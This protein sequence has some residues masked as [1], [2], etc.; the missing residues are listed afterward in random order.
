MTYRKIREHILFSS[1]IFIILSTL[2][3]ANPI[4]VSFAQHKQSSTDGTVTLNITNTSTD[5][6]KVL[7]WNTPLE[8]ILSANLFHIQK[9]K[10]SIPYTGRVV[11]R[12]SPTED[13]YTLFQAGE[14]R[15]VSISLPKYY[16]LS[17]KGTYDVTYNA[18]F[19][20]QASV[21]NVV[22]KSIP[23]QTTI[24]FTPSQQQSTLVQKTPANFNACS[25]SQITI[26]NS[27]HDEAIVIAKNAYDTLTAATPNTQGER[28]N[29]WF[30]APNNP[31]QT[32]ITTNFNKIHT[33]LDTKDIVFDCSCSESHIAHVYANQPYKIY[34]C[35]SFWSLETTGTDTHAG[36]VVHEVSH[37]NIVATTR[38]HAYGHSRAKALAISNPEKAAANAD[39]Y[40]YFAENSP[41]LTMDVPVID[42]QHINDIIGDLPLSGNIAKAEDYQ[43]F[44][45]T[46]PQ[47]GIYTFY[48][49]GD[50]DTQGSLYNA[51]NLQI[52]YNDDIIATQNLNFSVSHLLLQGQD[53]HLRINAYS[54]KTGNYVFNSTFHKVVASDFNADGVA[55]IMWR[56]GST[57]YIWYMNADGT[58]SH[59]KKL[60]TKSSKYK[61]AGIA[62][63]NADGV[64]DIM[65]RSGST[66]YI[67]YMNAD[68]SRNYKLINPKSSAYKVAGVADF[69]NDGI[70]DILW[71]KGST[72][73]IWY[74]NA[75]GTRDYKLINPKHAS[76]EV[77]GIADF[78]G[79]AVADILWRKKYG[80][81]GYIW[82][83]GTDGS[84]DSIELG[85]NSASYD[86][87]SVKDFNHDGIADIM[88]RS[89]SKSSIWYMKAN[90]GHKN[91]Y[92]KLS[93][94]SASYRVQQ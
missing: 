71:R 12:I 9:G 40:E 78:N 16:K 30:G 43:F 15:I 31:R 89:G 83:M 75:D 67:W 11:K 4:S 10:D 19:K 37:F 7:K 69:D 57:N 70:A 87:V 24:T 68:G 92:K 64:A 53:Y 52:E 32:T 60:G 86:I 3:I 61:V 94:M 18:V 29:T 81:K 44:N 49:T 48:T 56:K 80:S 39:S 2:S 85:D 76:Y 58:R 26:L 45:F 66:N 93:T 46:I 55:D 22:P 79:D 84:R 91:G 36:T 54:N 27:A 73:Y 74:M 28:Y 38:D 14:V 34:L 13:D 33:A 41:L 8:D 65:W 35:T 1:I 23:T 77:A 17:E 21:K 50:L 47:T 88:W 5:T 62:D 6:V 90:S 51:N 72:N 63:F 25:Q 42:A 82:Y 20:L 59:Y